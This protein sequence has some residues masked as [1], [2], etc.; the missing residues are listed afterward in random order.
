MYI[1]PHSHTNY[2]ELYLSLGLETPI[3]NKRKT[4]K[5]SLI[6]KIKIT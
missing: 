4:K 3:I 6:K 2:Y 5:Y 1:M